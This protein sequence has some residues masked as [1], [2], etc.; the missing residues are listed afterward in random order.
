MFLNSIIRRNPKLIESTVELHQLG[1]L[2]SNSY[3]LDIDM[4]YQNSKILYEEAK[5][6][7][8]KIFAMTKQIG[9]NPVALKA[10]KRAGID[11]CVT[12]I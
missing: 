12:V 4:I 5:K 11:A 3:I 1:Q 7:D 6:Y 2:P 9:R 8:L 10:I